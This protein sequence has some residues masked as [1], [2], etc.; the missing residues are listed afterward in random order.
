[1]SSEYDWIRQ[2]I[3]DEGRNVTLT[4]A[5]GTADPT[6]PWRGNSA[7]ASPLVVKCVTVRYKP[8]EVDNS[9]IYHTDMKGLVAVPL[10]GEDV[11]TYDILTDTAGDRRTWRVINCEKIEPGPEILLYI[12]QLRR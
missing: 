9:H 8:R 11:T 7:V 1:M 4:K 2:I 3:S 5:A 6:K 10:T 12:L